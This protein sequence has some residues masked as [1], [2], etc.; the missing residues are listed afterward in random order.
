M[1]AALPLYDV[2]A[3]LADA[4]LA[5]VLPQLIADCAARGVKGILVNAARRDEWALVTALSAKHEILY[6]ALGVHPFFLD[7]W[8][9]NSAAE[10]RQVIAS[11]PSGAKIIAIGE[12]GLDFL[13]HRDSAE[14]QREALAQQLSIAREHGLPVCLHNRK[15]W[16]E[17]FAMLK[18][19][20]ITELRGYCHHFGASRQIARQALDLGLFLSFCGPVADPRQRRAREAAQYAPLDRV[21]SESDAPDLPAPQFR[22]QLSQPWQVR[23]VVQAIAEIKQCDAETVAQAIARN[24]QALFFGEKS[25]ASSC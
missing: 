2:H 11:A 23:A 7:G 18:S 16:P 1:T 6:A 25:A 3:H 5:P 19:L 21:L 4:R 9:D 24:W 14:R 8:H 17:F 15:A 10:L 13:S 20:R 12:I 22:G